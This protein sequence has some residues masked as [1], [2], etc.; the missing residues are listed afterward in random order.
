MGICS[1]CLGQGR[2]DHLEDPETSRLLADD[3]FRNYGSRAQPS[4]RPLDEP[5]PEY[6]RQE[7][8]ALKTI[9]HSMSEDVVDIFTILPDSS[10]DVN[11]DRS[12]S[13]EPEINGF[14]DDDARAQ[15]MAYRTV[16]RVH[17][18]RISSP[19]GSSKHDWKDAKAAMG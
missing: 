19:M 4:R 1:S 11:Q 2:R 18:D 15:S 5:D 16:K 17:I 10:E 13:P 12:S 8:E 6:V 7:R 9:A 14:K 3:P